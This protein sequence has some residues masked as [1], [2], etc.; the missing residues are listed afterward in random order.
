[1]LLAAYTPATFSASEIS[2][3]SGKPLSLQQ[4]RVLVRAQR[5]SDLGIQ[6]RRGFA[7]SRELLLVQEQVPFDPDE[8]LEQDWREK[9]APKFAQMPEMHT[10]RYLQTDRLGGVYIAGTLILPEKMRADRDVVILTRHLVYEGDNIEII[11]PG[12]DV[13]VF[14]VES[15]KMTRR[16]GGSQSEIRRFRI[17]TVT[18]RT[19]GLPRASN[20][21]PVQKRGALSS[22][23][24]WKGDK[25]FLI[26]AAWRPTATA[27]L[28][29]VAFIQGGDNA[30]GTRGFDGYQGTA[31]TNGTQGDSGINGATGDCASSRN[32][33]PGLPGESGGYGSD[34]GAGQDAGN[35]TDAGNINYSIMSSNSG[36]YHFSAR[37]GD[38]GSGGFGGNGGF[39]GFGGTGGRGGNGASCNDCLIGPGNGGNGSNGSFGGSGGDG[40]DGGR[41]GDAGNGGTITVTNQSSNA[42]V[43]TDAGAGQGGQGGGG[44]SGGVGGSGGNGGAG[45]SAGSTNCVGFNPSAG[46]NG[47]SGGGG[48]A[49][50]PGQSASNGSNGSPGTANVQNNGGGCSLEEELACFEMGGSYFDPD[51]CA[52]SF[53]PHSPILID[54][55]GDGFELTNAVGGVNFDINPG[56]NVERLA[57]TAAGSDDVWLVLD[58]NSN[59]TIDNGAEL[60]GNYTPQ[61]PSPTPNGFLALA[62]YDKVASGGNRDRSIDSQDTIYASLRLWRDTNHDGVSESGEL[63][64]LPSM[65]V[66]SID[67]DYRE[68]RRRD[69]YGNLFRYRAKVYSANRKHLGRW[70]Y[71]VFLVS[72]P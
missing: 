66:E 17:P 26:N 50:Q 23:A 61:P 15:E 16:S 72:T 70:A 35:G 32:G 5:E 31:G 40:G 27:A 9:L 52:C 43:T 46:T 11:A 38:G 57:W 62:E 33:E 13:S 12:H 47:L 55:L 65:G 45:G 19:G 51:T 3:S 34:G 58:R 63:Y 14:I 41:G 54:T 67:L 48:S 4:T 24:V 25:P 71:D 30:D 42:T 22:P 8:L 10:T 44:G 21:T 18:I 53:N 36:A 37:G 2:G 39:G 64:T 28:N 1:M 56:G 7:R 29:N 20:R 59:G 6:R 68:S 69:R 49:G 60:F